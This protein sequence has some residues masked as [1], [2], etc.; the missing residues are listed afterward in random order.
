MAAA[1][2]DWDALIRHDRVH[3]SLYT[4]GAVFAAELE[5]IWYRTWV[6][7]G[8]ESE[9]PE[10][11][12]YVVKAIGPQSVIMSRDGRGEI[13]LLLNRCTHRANHRLRGPEGQLERVPVPVSRLDV[14]QYGQ[15]ARVPLQRG[16]RRYRAE[17]GARPG[18]A[19]ARRE[20]PG[21]RLRLLRRGRPQS[22][23]AP[24]RGRPGVGPARRALARPGEVQLTAG[25]LRHR[26]K[27]NWKMLLENETDGYHPQFVH[28]SIFSVADSG[29]GDLYGE[30]S[31]ALARDLRRRAHRKRP[32]AGVPPDRQAARLV[33]HRSPS[34]CPTTSRQME[35]VHGRERA[36]ELLID[37]SPHVMIFPNLFIAEIQL[38]VMQ[39]LARRRD[40]PARHRGPVQGRAGHEP[41]DAPAD[42]GLGRAGRVPARRRL[43]DVRA[44]PARRAGPQPRMARADA[45]AQ[46]ETPTTTASWSATATDEVPQRGIWRHYRALMESMSDAPA[47]D[48][49][50]S[51]PRGAPRRTSSATT[52]GR[53]CGPTTGSTGC[54]RTAM[55]IRPRAGDVDHLR[56]PLAHRHAD[57]AAARPA[58]ATPRTRRSRLR[59][60]VSNVELLGEDDRGIHVGANF[61]VHESRERGNTIW[62]GRSDYTLRR[63][64]GG[65]R[66]AF[67]KVRLIDNDRALL[68]LSF[69][70]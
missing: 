33:R 64:T 48:R 30:S 45:G 4:D 14:H 35:S 38:F 41:A 56:Q 54:R 55:T 26:V 12:D 10:P 68:T 42:D 53:R 23:R 31:T 69:L 6:F 58:S 49:A 67:K 28:A 43:G 40:R 47:R 27:A 17:D 5:R 11:N 37:G 24:G 44:Q 57:Q 46:R 50:V 15:A 1:D 18:A 36:R 25:W 8:H 7:V 61:V 39:P 62:A 70:I 65:L 20:P 16:I 29:I 66:M 21:V 13:H 22:R 52:S 9:V 59:H 3:G 2:I 34:A 19:S 60:V 63:G 32:A 51:L